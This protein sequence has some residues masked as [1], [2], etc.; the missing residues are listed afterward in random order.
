TTQHHDRLRHRIHI[1][2]HI[3]R[4]N[5][6][7]P[8]A[9]LPQPI[10]PRPVPFRTIPAVMRRSIDFDDHL[11]RR[12]IEI[13]HKGPARML[14]AKAD[15]RLAQYPPQQNFRKRHRPAQLAGPADGALAGLSRH[16]PS[17]TLTGGPPP[18]DRFAATGRISTKSL[19]SANRFDAQADQPKSSLSAKPM[20]RGAAVPKGTWWRGQVPPH[21]TAPRCFRRDT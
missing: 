9:P 7:H 19:L 6:H 16:S 2:Q 15:L 21:D 5:S 3:A 13:R 1:R 12:A 20:G 18:H 4:W 17:T 10:I 8:V 11:R 14:P